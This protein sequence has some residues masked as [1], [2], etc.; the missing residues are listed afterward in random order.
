MV[1]SHPMVK[2]KGNFGSSCLSCTE[3]QVLQIPLQ[4]RKPTPSPRGPP[5]RICRRI[6]Q[7]THPMDWT[8]MLPTGGAAGQGSA[9]RRCAILAKTEETPRAHDGE[10]GGR[11]S[12]RGWQRSRESSSAGDQ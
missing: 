5:R 3:R 7:L 12:G 11:G 9:Q 4:I 10:D 2:V 6:F 1:L 8:A